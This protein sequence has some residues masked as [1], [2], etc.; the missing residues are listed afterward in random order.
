MYLKIKLNQGNGK[1]AV[2]I[3]CWPKIKLVMDIILCK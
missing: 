2:E 1:N 3:F